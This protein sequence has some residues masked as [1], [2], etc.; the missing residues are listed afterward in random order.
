MEAVSRVASAAQQIMPLDF[1]YGSFST[2][3]VKAQART[4]PLRPDC[5][6]KLSS[7]L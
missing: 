7:I 6:A 1:S 3:M 5:V 4:C 2:E